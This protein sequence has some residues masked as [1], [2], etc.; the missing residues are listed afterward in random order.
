MVDGWVVNRRI[1]IPFGLNSPLWDSDWSAFTGMGW[2][3]YWHL[4]GIDD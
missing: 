3:G 2:M 4:S 1:R